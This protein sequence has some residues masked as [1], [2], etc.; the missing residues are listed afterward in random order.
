M[1]EPNVILT[2]GELLF[3]AAKLPTKGFNGKM[4]GATYE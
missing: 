2:Y 3:L 1:A 4:D